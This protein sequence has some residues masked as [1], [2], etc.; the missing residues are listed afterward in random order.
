M[1]PHRKKVFRCSKCCLAV[2]SDHNTASSQHT[3]LQVVHFQRCEHASHQMCVKLQLTL[4]LPLLR[5]PQLYPH[6][7]LSTLQS[8]S[9]LTC[10]SVPALYAS[11]WA[12]LPYLSRHCTVRLKMFFVSLVFY[13]LF[14]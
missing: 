14:V 12:V 5:A 4:G 13:I 8:V 6:H 11:H 10:H 9:L 2:I 3:N 1:L 7:I